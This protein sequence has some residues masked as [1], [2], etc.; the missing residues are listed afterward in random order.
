MKLARANLIAACPELDPRLIER[1]LDR[2]GDDYF[3]VFD[4]HTVARHI[5]AIARL[6][7]EN[8]VQV[9]MDRLGDNRV[10]C[11]IVAFD[12]RG[13][14]SVIT[15]LLAAFGINILSGHVFTYLSASSSAAQLDRRRLR[16][17]KPLP[18]ALTRRCIIDY[19]SGIHDP[20]FDQNDWMEQFASSM[21]EALRL[22]E[23]GAEADVTRV[24]HLV[25]E[26]VAQRLSRLQTDAP[27]ALYPV[28]IRIDDKP[29][30]Y[31][32]ILVV[33]QDTPA[34]LYSFS[35]ALALRG[36]SIEGVR[37]QTVHGAVHDEIDLLDARGRR[38]TDPET[39]DR[40]RFSVLLTK[41]FT[42][43]LGKAADSYAALS[44]FDHLVEEI[45]RLPDCSQWVRLFQDAEALR[46]LAQIL[47]TSD[48]I[49]EE[50]VRSQYEVLLPMLRA[51]SRRTRLR[52]GKADLRERLR[53]AL[54]NSRDFDERRRRLNEWKDREI[55]L[56]DLDH[57]LRAPGDVRAL[58]EPLTRLA[59]IVIEHAT[60]SVFARLAERH[61]TPRTVGGLPAPYAVFGLGKF[62][63][64]ALGYASDIEI[65]VVYGD[66]GATDGAPPMENAQFFAL[67]AEEIARCVASKQEGIFRVDLRLRPYG[68]SGPKATSL[69]AFC[70][71]YGAAGPAH[72]FE[73]LALTRLRRVAGDRELGEKIERLRDEF[74]YGGAALDTRE[75]RQL[76]ERQFAE[77]VKD[78]RDN[79]KFG[80][81]ALVDVEYCVQFLQVLHGKDHPEL[82]SPRIHEALNSLAGA[83]VVEP[84]E[85]A[86]LTE[87]YDFL[88]RLING[89]RMLRGNALDLSLPEAG[90]D[91]YG[92][93]ARRM[94]YEPRE[95]LSPEQQLLIA[96]ETHTAIVR[97]FIARH[98]GAARLPST[99]Q[100]NIADLLMSDHVPA[101]VRH[102]VLR[103]HGF[104][105]PAR[106]YVNWRKLSG[107]EEEKDRFAK[108]AILACD[109]LRHSADPDM[110]LNNWERFVR[111]LPDPYTH[112]E[113]LFAQPRRME[114]LL[115]IFAG[116][117]FLADTIVRAPEF[118]DWCTNPVILQG[119]RGRDLLRASLD[120]FSFT[121][122]N[123][124]EQWLDDL[125]RFHCR[126]ILRIGA[127]DI[128]LRV[129]L[130]DVM[131]DL[132]ALA[133]VAADACLGRIWD[134]WGARTS[135][136]AA[137]A[138]RENFCV[139]ALGKLGGAELNYSSDIDLIAAYD[140][141][142]RA[143]ADLAPQAA[144]A[145]VMDELHRGLAAHSEEGYVYRVD[146]RLRP[147]GAA[148]EPASS[149]AALSE[150]YRKHAALWEIQA[151]L[152]ARP[153]AGNLSVGRRFLESIRPLIAQPRPK[154][155]VARSIHAMRR[156][157]VRQAD[158]RGGPIDVKT[159]LGGIRDIEFLVQGLQLAN[160]AANPDL[161]T[162]N[163]LTALESL[164]R[165]RLLAPEP[166]DRLRQGYLL[167]RRIEHCLQL[168][169]NR[170]VHALPA[171]PRQLQALARRVLGPAH[172]A[173]DFMD[174]L[175][176]TQT[177]VRAAYEEFIAS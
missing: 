163:T 171:D 134:A 12:Y 135:R 17:A 92:H 30:L 42:Y 70:R 55:Y 113:L 63:G 95:N 127:R 115:S 97:R 85:A 125:R 56:I 54:G 84:G 8:P 101:E 71:Y 175:R 177:R 10:D 89:L 90:A 51:P 79:A 58:A 130:S 107:H 150:Y 61:G 34:F 86:A 68:N 161:F 160:L 140:D 20:S 122:R 146:F 40:I 121:N 99:R 168:F 32:T 5:R 138:L 170:Q 100:A 60:K 21:R 75:L 67:L 173:R 47:G 16:R 2:L 88:R 53:R 57:I 156:M 9:I 118:L 119:S 117:Q 139:L 76:R 114:L 39:L 81:G 145:K 120:T 96:F 13:E 176:D 64:V 109:S 141:S 112:Y 29:G 22:L 143:R 91:E 133:E 164:E 7:P 165:A 103:R 44:R 77:K 166:A 157:A 155:E 123:Q 25:N 148:G 69:E 14:F 28:D 129:P 151:L 45:Q 172:T 1:H 33:A 87:A 104:A 94:G 98:F 35:N 23:S 50:F 6:S 108:L 167:L 73:K 38:I 31:T 152:K 18:A 36:I 153:I 43:F 83:G 106:A 105:D 128:C 62:G 136:S 116:S 110:A 144:Y 131:A 149:L 159:G 82:R 169:E 19:F 52:F 102:D 142:I 26:K 72:S 154:E 49:W 132:S 41:Q 11:T 27:P 74:V 4:L 147:R 80:P 111:A 24:R 37:I 59:E 93:L 126:E 48:F 174:T 15:G 3:R 124:P 46:N 162:G 66:N 158:A 137:R 78:S 65:L